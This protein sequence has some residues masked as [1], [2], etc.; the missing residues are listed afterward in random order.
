LH[1]P[2]ITK[3][4]QAF[5]IPHQ[6]SYP[7]IS[8]HIYDLHVS[9]DASTLSSISN[10]LNKETQVQTLGFVIAIIF[11]FIPISFFI[12]FVNRGRATNLGV[13]SDTR[14]IRN[15]ESFEKV[16]FCLVRFEAF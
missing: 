10:L 2:F 16:D 9:H 11:A 15:Y 3:L 4:S 8:L 7:I 5:Y 1:S 14:P 13:L 6:P 12:A